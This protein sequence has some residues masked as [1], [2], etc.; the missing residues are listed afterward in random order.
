MTTALPKAKPPAATV[1][2]A[3]LLFL[4]KG[5]TVLNLG[6]ILEDMEPQQAGRSH[7]Q[8]AANL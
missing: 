1:L 2:L 4:R 7:F 5:L 3:V 6:S 8:P